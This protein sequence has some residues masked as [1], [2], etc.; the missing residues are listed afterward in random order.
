MAVLQEAEN[1]LQAL[2]NTQTVAGIPA[3]EAPELV[4]GYLFGDLVR[5]PHGWSNSMA[6]GI[7]W[8]LCW[9]LIA[10]RLD[11]AGR[12]KL[13]LA[14][15]AVGYEGTW[16]WVIT[17]YFASGRT[18]LYFLVLPLFGWTF[19]VV[20]ALT[21]LLFWQNGVKKVIFGLPGLL[22]NFAGKQGW[23]HY[24]CDAP[25]RKASTPCVRYLQA[26]TPRTHQEGT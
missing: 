16:A 26:I 21:G 13:A 4:M 11:G 18:A 20:S 1:W 5:G 9:S 22:I 7:V 17:M 8:F 23:L 25:L 2:L 12:W 10:L 3:G 15:Y 24:F 6:A 19:T 14:S